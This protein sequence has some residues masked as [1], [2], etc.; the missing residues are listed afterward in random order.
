MYI[1]LNKYLNYFAFVILF[2]C[3]NYSNPENNNV[4]YDS[5]SIFKN[6]LLKYHNYKIS[7]NVVKFL[8]IPK[9]MGCD[10]CKNKLK[11]YWNQNPI[12][13][14]VV[15]VCSDEFAS[16]TNFAQNKNVLIDS[17]CYFEKMNIGTQNISL[18]T[19]SKGNLK[20]FSNLDATNIDEALHSFILKK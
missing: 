4:N 20:H 8:V 12:Q 17:S 11:N 14:N 3:C 1:K 19:F 16:N 7:D 5:S 6:Y 13:D 15:I 10:G 18:F 2:N 9:H